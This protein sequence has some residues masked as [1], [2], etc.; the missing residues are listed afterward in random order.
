MNYQNVSYHD[1]DDGIMTPQES[2]LRQDETKIDS[3]NSTLADSAV[4]GSF[5]AVG[6]VA[7]VAA[8]QPFATTVAGGQVMYSVGRAGDAYATR[9]AAQAHYDQK[10]QEEKDYLASR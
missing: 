2:Q 6:A 1:P 7:G 10:L 5:G 8:N 3:C 9:E 4:T